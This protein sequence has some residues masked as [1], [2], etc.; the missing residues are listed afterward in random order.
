MA[1]LPLLSPHVLGIRRQ[2]QNLSPMVRI[3]F[4]SKPDL[5]ADSFYP[6][7]SLAELSQTHRSH[8]VLN[9][10]QLSQKLERANEVGNNWNSTVFTQA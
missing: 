7:C 3:L 6:I 8:K 2:V 9:T 4:I 1:S 5:F 10:V